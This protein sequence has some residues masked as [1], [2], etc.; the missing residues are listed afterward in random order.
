MSV[1]YEHVFIK[2][3]GENDLIVSTSKK[4]YHILLSEEEM[5]DLQTLLIEEE[6]EYVLFDTEKEVVVFDDR[7]N[8]TEMENEELENIHE[9]VN[10]EGM[11][12]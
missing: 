7:L 2:E 9:G 12:D 11:I 5:S 3:I 6:V 10:D 8:M 1:K 4:D